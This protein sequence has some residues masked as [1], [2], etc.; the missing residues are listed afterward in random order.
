MLG[1]SGRSAPSGSLPVSL[2]VVAAAAAVKL[3]VILL[4]S[5][6]ERGP[7]GVF[8]LGLAALECVYV[9]LRVRSRSAGP[10]ALAERSDTSARGGTLSP[11]ALA[12]A[13][14]LV[15]LWTVL[16]AVWLAL[17]D[18]SVRRSVCCAHLVVRGM[19]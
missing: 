16:G 1:T 13:A 4:S 17:D 15:V 6:D 2:I 8:L 19:R 7:L 12:V 3:A 14:G 5:D 10:T 18:A 11:L 9:A